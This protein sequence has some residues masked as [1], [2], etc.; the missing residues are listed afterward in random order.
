MSGRIQQA[1]AKIYI[2]TCTEPASF[3]FSAAADLSQTLVN[4]KKK[5]D[6][7]KAVDTK[8]ERVLLKIHLS[9]KVKEDCF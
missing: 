7:K 3:E 8:I 6:K 5:S 9:Y 1:A 4:F 2:L